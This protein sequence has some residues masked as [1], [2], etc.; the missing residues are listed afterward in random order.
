MRSSTKR[1]LSAGLSLIFLLIALIFFIYF[2]KP[3][4]S[5]IQSLRIELFK[6]QSLVNN[7]KSLIEQFKNLNQDYET[8]KKNQEIFSLILPQ[9]VSA[10]EALVQISGLLTN[11]NLNLL[12]FTVNKPNLLSDNQNSKSTSSASFIKPLGTFD[13]N[14][15]ASGDYSSFKKFFK[16]T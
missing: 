3:V 2:V 8:Q 12:S 9:S 13:I 6:K 14:L 5:E 11:N 16:S 15:K 10:G 4:Y 7:Q 1:I